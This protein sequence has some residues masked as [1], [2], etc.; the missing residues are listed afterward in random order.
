[1]GDGEEHAAVTFQ[2]P[3]DTSA[4]VGL[5]NALLQNAIALMV[6]LSRGA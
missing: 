5:H 4:S 6:L 2:S 3:A 1:M